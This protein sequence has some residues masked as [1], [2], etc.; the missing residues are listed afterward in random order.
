MKTFKFELDTP[1]C[2]FYSGETEAITLTLPDGDITVY[3]DHSFFTAPV[4][5]GFLKIKDKAGTWKN[6]FISEGFLEVKAHNTILMVDA[7]EW[8]GE[9]DGER[10]ERALAAAEETIASSMLKF[11]ITAAKAAARRAKFRL[12]VKEAG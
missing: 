4:L 9:I 3:A 12:K 7:A 11:E 10:A 8:P 6:V 1:Y 2:R 5:A